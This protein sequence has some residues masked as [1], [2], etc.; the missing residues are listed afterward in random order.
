MSANTYIPILRNRSNEQEVIQQFGG[1]RN[2]SEQSDPIDLYPLVE[3]SNADDLHNLDVFYDAGEEVLLELPVYQSTRNTNFGNAIQETLET[4]GD[5]VGFYLSHTDRVTNP[6]IS[7]RGERN[8]S[9]EVHPEAQKLLF[10]SFPTVTHRLFV[11]TKPFDV[12]QRASLEKLSEVIRPADR[13]L[14]DVLDTGYNEKLQSNLEYLANRFEQ[15]ECAILNLLNAFKNESNN[16]TPKVAGELGIR[17]FGD[18]GIN[19]RYPG[20]GGRGQKVT[21]RHY[22]PSHGYVA[23]FE[24]TDY[25]SAS[26]ALTLWEDWKLDH[27]DFC[28]RASN[29]STAN[30]SAWK[31]IRTG[32]YITS[33]L[34]GEF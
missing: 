7:G 3:I 8:I 17:G 2:F 23:E 32:H 30:P 11:R 22:H 24:G 27:C 29:M 33:M 6:V 14:F 25:E 5:Q 16:L 10:K 20:G 26:E 28:R 15:Q 18:F 21:I 1:L 13:V 12:E 34:R 9:Y 19:V 4:Y 31:R